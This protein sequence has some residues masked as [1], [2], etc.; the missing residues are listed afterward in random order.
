MWESIRWQILNG[1]EIEVSPEHRS[2]AWRELI[3]NVANNTPLDNT[4][5]TM[6]QKADFKNFDYNTP[7]VYNLKTKTLTMYNERIRAALNRPVRANDQTI[8]VNIVHVVLLFICIILL[9]VLAVFS[10][11]NGA[12]NAKNKNAPTKIK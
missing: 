2:L 5:R 11:T 6:F 10:N 9:I 4:F 8:N 12:I 7:I 3:I 1:D